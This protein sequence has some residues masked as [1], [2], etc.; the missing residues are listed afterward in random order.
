MFT[1]ISVAP[2]NIPTKP[3]LKNI[4]DVY[5]PREKRGVRRGRERLFKTHCTLV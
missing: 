5:V 2:L 1:Y 3:A 4:S